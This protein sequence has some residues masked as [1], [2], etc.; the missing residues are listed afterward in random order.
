MAWTRRN[1][2]GNPPV[3]GTTAS[4]DEVGLLPAH[5]TPK[6]NKTVNDLPCRCDASCCCRQP[7]RKDGK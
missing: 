3:N 1:L 6:P 4:I 7:E 2:T 5:V